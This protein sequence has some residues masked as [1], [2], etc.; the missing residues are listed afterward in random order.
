MARVLAIADEEDDVLCARLA[1]GDFGRVDAVVSCG[2]LSPRYLDYVATMANAPLLYVR[3]NHDTDASGYGSMGGTA[4][5]G[6]VV[7]IAGLR[8]AGLDGSLLYREGIVGY[9]DQQ[10]W[11]RALRLAA[12]AKLSGGVDVLVTHAPPRG[13]GDL[14]DLA[15]R[16]FACLNWLL[17]A[18]RPRLLLCGHVHLRCGGGPRERAHPSGTCI[19]NA[20]GYWDGVV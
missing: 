9:S 17:G 18:L 3:G 1:S 19:V 14:D 20:C 8:V 13:H 7:R 6:R 4:L 12:V 10:M 2:D 11:V 5:D 15:H 16:G